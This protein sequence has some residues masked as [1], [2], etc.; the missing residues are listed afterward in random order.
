M[1]LPEGSDLGKIWRGRTAVSREN[2]RITRSTEAGPRAASRG[3]K[4][5][6]EAKHHAGLGRGRDFKGEILDDPPPPHLGNLIGIRLG[7]FA[8]GN[9]ESV[10]QADADVPA[11]HRAH[12]DESHLMFADG[13]NR[14]AIVGAEQLVRGPAHVHQVLVVR[15][16]AAENV[17]DSLDEEQRPCSIETECIP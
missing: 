13:Q 17:E 1:P 2:T 12:G 15:P 3:Q 16:D 4:T 7:E 10:L 14:P 11:H 6:L 8:L 9:M 5:S